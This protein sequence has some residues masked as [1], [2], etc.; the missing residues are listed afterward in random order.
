VFAALFTAC[1]R[2]K[3]RIVLDEKIL[4]PNDPDDAYQLDTGAATAVFESAKTSKR[5]R[6]AVMDRATLGRP[7]GNITYGYR[8]EYDPKTGKLIG[9]GIDPVT[10]PIVKNMIERVL[11]GESVFTICRELNAAGVPAPHGGEWRGNNTGKMICNPAYIARRMWNG[12]DVGSAS[13]PPLITEAQHYQLKAL[14]TDP[15]RD[16]YRQ[17][18]RVKYLGV[19]IYRCG[20][21]GSPVRSRQDIRRPVKDRTAY[22]CRDCRKVQRVQ[23]QLDDLIEELMV[24][25]LAQPDLVDEL[26]RGDDS[27]QKTSADEVLR[28]RG[29]LKAAKAAW[30]ADRLSLEAYMEMEA[31]TLPKVKAAE[32]RAKPRHVPSVVYDTAGPDARAKWKALSIVEKRA[33]VEALIVVTLMPMEGQWDWSPNSV[34]VKRRTR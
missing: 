8:S 18:T 22:Q 3:V 12:N 15:E 26:A 23:R 21:C 30:D 25:R 17:D 19:G 6:R 11:A 14:Y 5:V 27:E 2:A 32:E 1:Q 33:I 24:R 16:R 29:K 34:V 28:L 7:H 20:A 10:G 4:D 31:L 9:R 13:W